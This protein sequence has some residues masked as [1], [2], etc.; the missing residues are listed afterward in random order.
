MRGT[1]EE[2]VETIRP[3][4]NPALVINFQ[5]AKIISDL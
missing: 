5:G 3:E 4:F 1:D 2:Q